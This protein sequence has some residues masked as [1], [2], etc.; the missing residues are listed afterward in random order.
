MPFSKDLFVQLPLFVH[1]IDWKLRNELLHTASNSLGSGLSQPQNLLSQLSILNSFQLL[2]AVA[3]SA[4]DFLN[5]CVRSC[6]F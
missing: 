1:W 3:P 2:G 4:L 5:F 6:R